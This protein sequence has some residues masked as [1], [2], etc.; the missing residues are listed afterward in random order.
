MEKMPIQAERQ[1]FIPTYENMAKFGGKELKAELEHLD[2]DMD[3]VMS[4]GMS[5][6][7]REFIGVFE[8]AGGNIYKRSDVVSFADQHSPDV[9]ERNK[10]IAR[11][12]I[13][14]EFGA[15]DLFSGNGLTRVDPQSRYASEI[16]QEFGVVETFTFERDPLGI[17]DLEKAGAIRIVPAE[18]IK[19]K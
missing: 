5:A 15:N 1:S 4:E 12:I 18:M 11:H 19:G 6:R 3:E 2:V 13:Q 8:A 7:Y 10:F 14:T 17:A 16:G 9:L